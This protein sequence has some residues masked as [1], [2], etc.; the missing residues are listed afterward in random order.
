MPTTFPT[1]IAT[2]K[3]EVGSLILGNGIKLLE[4]IICEYFVL[5]QL[6]NKLTQ[7]SLTV[8]NLNSGV[9]TLIDYSL[10]IVLE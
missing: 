7:P 10:T 1:R 5:Y 3:G 6:G 2:A 8:L 4:G 9:R